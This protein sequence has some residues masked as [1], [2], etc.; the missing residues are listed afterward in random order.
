MKFTILAIL[1]LTPTWS[2]YAKYNSMYTAFYYDYYKANIECLYPGEEGK[3][4][5][6][7]KESDTVLIM[8]C[9]VD[10]YALCSAWEKKVK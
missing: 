3:S 7:G 5:C 8:S 2:D 4:L 6:L 10:R 1:A 9:A